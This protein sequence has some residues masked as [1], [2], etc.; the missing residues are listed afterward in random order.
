MR[1]NPP[2]YVKQKEEKPCF[3]MRKLV[4]D[5]YEPHQHRSH[6][7]A[8][9]V[10]FGIELVMALAVDNPFFNSPRDR[11]PCIAG[12]LIAVGELAQA[13]CTTCFHANA[14]SIAIQHGNC[15][16]VI[17]PLGRNVPSGLPL[18]IPFSLAQATASE[19]HNPAA[20]SENANVPPAGRSSKR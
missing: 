17:G 18:T 3:L 11:F 9:C 14:C 19:Y 5:S 4:H 20:V 12:H 8:G 7:C 6:F 13:T 15:S 10:P 2:L 16:R 1:N